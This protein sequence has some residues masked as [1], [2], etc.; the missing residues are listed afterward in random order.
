ME[1]EFSIVNTRRNIVL[2]VEIPHKQ[3]LYKLCSSSRLP[4]C[5]RYS[6]VFF[7]HC[8][9]LTGEDD[10][11]KLK[12]LLGCRCRPCTSAP[13]DVTEVASQDNSKYAH[14][15][16]TLATFTSYLGTKQMET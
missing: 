14:V 1:I 3:S 5:P 6:P 10:S 2:T 11:S 4:P 15:K 13:G 9:S 12:W 7:L 16:S 8:H